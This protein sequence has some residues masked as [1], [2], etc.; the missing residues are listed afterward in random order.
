[1]STKGSKRNPLS[2]D[3]RL[4]GNRFGMW[5]VLAYDHSKPICHK[6]YLC[7]CDCGT[8]KIVGG[9]SIVAGKSTNCGCQRPVQAIRQFAKPD[10]E[11]SANAVIRAYKRAARERGFV[12]EL[13]RED[14]MRITQQDC[15]YCGS[16]PSNIHKNQK[17]TGDYVYNGIDRV[18]NSLGYIVGNVVPSCWTCNWSKNNM[19]IPQFIEW[20]AKL[21][22][23]FTEREKFVYV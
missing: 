19:T 4:I 2:L 21:Y 10:G 8:K 11:A 17:S 1:M 9:H 7:E 6:F 14:F 23:R 22:K 20:I 12:Y 3:E 15:Y 13:E 18:D 16:P 5:V